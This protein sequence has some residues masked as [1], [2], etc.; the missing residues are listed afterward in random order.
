MAEV[1]WKQVK[2]ALEKI[3]FIEGIH[4]ARALAPKLYTNWETIVKALVE[5]AREAEEQTSGKEEEQFEE[6]TVVEEVFTGQ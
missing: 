4:L 5:V 6:K 3:S 2:Q 1:D